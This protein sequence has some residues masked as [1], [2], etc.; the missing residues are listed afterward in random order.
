MQ[1]NGEPVRP[2]QSLIKDDAAL[3]QSGSLKEDYKGLF[4]ENEALKEELRKEKFYH[5]NLYNQWSRLNVEVIDKNR[6]LEQLRATQDPKLK[7][8]QYAF[9]V[10]LLINVVFVLFYFS[11]PKDANKY[12]GTDRTI[13]ANKAANESKTDSLPLQN[14]VLKSPPASIPAKELS[15][16]N[17]LNQ[18][19]PVIKPASKVTLKYLVKRK[20][21]FHNE[22]DNSTRRKTFVLPW[23]DTYGIL[24]ALDDRNGFIYVVFTNH[25]GRTSKGWILKSDLEP[26]KE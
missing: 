7:I 12:S 25:A 14:P 26:V 17:S 16:Q 3:H 20:S 13:F 18:Q 21:Y 9:Y 22:P 8:Y 2:R 19:K 23:N 24:T 6:Q 5:Q 10:L 11:F 15:S 4:L 1:N